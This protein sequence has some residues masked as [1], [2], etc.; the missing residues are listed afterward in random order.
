MRADDVIVERL[1]DEIDLHLD[2]RQ[3]ITP[4]Q[5]FVEGRWVARLADGFVDGLMI[6]EPF[7]PK[8]KGMQRR[9][10]ERLRA[11]AEV[12]LFASKPSAH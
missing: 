7:P 10:F 3:R 1:H 4:G 12:A 6:L 11:R 8:P 5:H 9:T 2:R